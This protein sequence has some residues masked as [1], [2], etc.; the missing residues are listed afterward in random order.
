MITAMLSKFHVA[1]GV[2]SLA[3][4]YLQ[5]LMSRGHEVHVFTHSPI[6]CGVPPD[7][8]HR[9][10][11]VQLNPHLTLDTPGT[12]SLIAK[13]CRDLG[14]EVIHVQV[15]C[16][17][18]DFLLPYF[19]HSLPPI[20][21]TY[22]LAYGGGSWLFTAGFEVAWRMT[23]PATKK[24]DHIMLVDPGQK[25]V[26]LRHGIPEE[27]L[28]VVQNGVDTN[29]FAPQ[30]R[31][32]NDDYVSFVY[33]GRLSKEKGL[34][35]LLKAFKKYHQEN[36]RSR[37]ILAGD[38]LFKTCLDDYVDDGSIHWLG[39]VPHDRVPDVLHRA[40]VFVSAQNIGGLGMSVLEAMSCGLPVITTAIGET[41]RLLDNNEGILVQPQS[42]SELV[43][44]MQLLGDDEQLRRSMG[45]RGREKILRGYSWNKQCELIEQVY[46]RVC[47]ETRHSRR[48]SL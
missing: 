22:H 24:Y 6:V 2:C 29:L 48:D 19:K 34:D 31:D 27:K 12:V 38:G 18:T 16:G 17:S 3:N 10:H 33:V 44:A 7:R 13:T 47:E 15:P 32:R 23:L 39:P 37:L 4:A 25:S 11:A 21:M 26:F 46:Q 43:R 42:V 30:T 20:V 36:P 40:D 28:T 14:V 45:I 8:I 9:F 35:V 5:G 1:D 41:V